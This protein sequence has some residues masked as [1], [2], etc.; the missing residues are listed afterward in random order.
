MK[1]SLAQPSPPPP[2][3]QSPHHQRRRHAAVP[4]PKQHIH[5]APHPRHLQQHRTS[6]RHLLLARRIR[7]PRMVQTRHIPITRVPNQGRR[8]IP[9]ILRRDRLEYLMCLSIPLTLTSN[10]RRTSG[11][12]RRLSGRCCR[13]SRCLCPPPSMAQRRPRPQGL[14]RQAWRTLSWFLA[15]PPSIYPNLWY[16]SCILYLGVEGTRMYRCYTPDHY[17]TSL[18]CMITENV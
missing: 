8:A 5:C 4:T 1:P 9:P 17:Y 6:L 7:P 16:N 10:P 12:H 18:G 11:H 2:P 15:S 14:E 3:S 13:T